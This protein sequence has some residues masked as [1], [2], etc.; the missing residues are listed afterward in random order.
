MGLE[1]AVAAGTHH[2]KRKAAA[3]RLDLH[4]LDGFLQRFDV[5]DGSYADAREAAQRAD[6]E[7]ADARLEVDRADTILLAFL[8]LEGDEEASAL[9][10]V[11]RQR[12]NHLHVREAVLQVEAANQIAIGLDA[13]WV[14]DVVAAQE[15]QQVGFVGLDDVLEAIGRI[16]AVADEVDGFDRGLAAFVDCEDQI[17]AVV[18]LVDHLGRDG[19]VIAARMAIDFHD[20]L[21]VGLHH[22]A[23]QRAARLGLDFSGELLV[24]DLLVALEGDAVDDRVFDHGDDNSPA[25]PADLY[26]LEQAGFDQRLQAVIDRGVVQ[27]TA[28]AGL[29]I[30]ADGL[31]L[32]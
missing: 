7:I 14:V 6:V 12:R 3:R 8:D 29:E 18:R 17:D 5:I 15:A 1:I 22:R 10:I 23:R 28:R 21:R 25:G 30:G 4:L 27:P 13:V 11:F 24:L 2:R 20:S 16:V 9:R 26:I 19:H 31:D 32:D